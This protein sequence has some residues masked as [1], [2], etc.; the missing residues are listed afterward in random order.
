MGLLEKASLE[1]QIGNAPCTA[2][3]TEEIFWLREADDYQSRVAL[4]NALA[5]QYRFKDAIC[6]YQ[7][8]LR[9][10][11][12]VWTVF[13]RLAVAYLTIRRFAEA[14]EQYERCLAIGADPKAVALPIGVW[15]YL[16]GEYS[17]AAD[18]FAKCLPCGDEMAIA[19]I[20]WHTLCRYRICGEPDLLPMYRR[21]MHAG[22]HTAYQLAVSVFCGDV[23]W[24]DA[25]AEADQELSELN[26]VIALYGICG[27]LRSVGETA[28]S[29]EFLQALLTYRTYWPCIAYLAAWNDAHASESA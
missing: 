12:D 14:K 13:S 2:E 6:A 27:Y 18:W 3:D 17:T 7:N 22:H 29:T 15:H 4:G 10:R 5:G 21:E 9:I 16:K 23:S 8:A 24:K 20:Y 25:A 11:R 1:S 28:K 26:R 19:V